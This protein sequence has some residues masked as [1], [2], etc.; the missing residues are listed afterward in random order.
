MYKS[1]IIV[2]GKCN[3]TT[4]E[5]KNAFLLHVG[6]Y[7]KGMFGKHTAV[8]FFKDD[9]V[10]TS[11][12]FVWSNSGDVIDIKE[13]K[14]KESSMNTLYWNKPLQTKE[15]YPV[16]VIC[17]DRKTVDKSKNIVLIEQEGH[18]WVAESDDD[19]NAVRLFDDN[20]FT[21]INKPKILY[22]NIYNVDGE[23]HLDK[24]YEDIADCDKYRSNSLEFVKVA[25]IEL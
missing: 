18:E 1:V 5:S 9:K 11:N 17:S 14:S 7:N 2:N 19:G 16:R 4:F 21:I 23:I 12:D 20:I 15:G 24:P 13:N 10:L 3:I 22:F 25:S 8:T 6:M